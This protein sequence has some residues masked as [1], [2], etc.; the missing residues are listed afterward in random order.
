MTTTSKTCTHP[1]RR[2]SFMKSAGALGL[3]AVLPAQAQDQ[4]SRVQ[5]F[6]LSQVRLTA[7]PW[8]DAV[9]ANRRFLMSLEP[10]RLL[11]RFRENAGLP[12]KGQVY[13]G[14]E[15]D[16]IA[17]HTLG[18]YLSALSLMHAQ[19]GD[20]EARRRGDHI[21]AELALCQAQG[22]DGYVAALGRRV[23]TTVLND[24][25]SLFDDVMAGRIDP[26]FGNLNGG[27]APLYNIHKQLAGLLDAHLHLGNEQA[28]RVATG[29]AGYLDHVFSMLDEEKTQLVLDCEYGGLQESLAELYAR[30]GERRW[31]ALARRLRHEKTFRAVA[32]GRDQLDK[33]HSNTEMPKYVGSARLYEVG[34]GEDNAAATRFFWRTVTQHRSYVVGGNGDREWFYPKGQ[35]SRYITDQTCEHCSTYN[36]LKI[37]RHLFQWEPHAKWFDYYERAHLNHTLA[38]QDPATG[39]FAYMMPTMAGAKRT[40][41]QPTDQFWCCMGSG[42]E[43]HAKHGDSIWWHGGSA[44]APELFVNEY[45]PSM[46]DWP[47]VGTFELM[48][49]Y[50]HSERIDLLVTEAF[51]THAVAIRLRVPGWTRSPVLALN[52]KP[53]PVQV[54]DGYATLVRRLRQGDRIGLTLP[55]PLYREATPDNPSIHAYLH[56]PMALAADLGADGGPLLPDEQPAVFKGEEPRRLA[57]GAD[58]AGHSFTLATTTG[59]TLELRPF[60][61]QWNQRTALY[62]PSFDRQQWPA[63]AGRRARAKAQRQATIA[64]SVDIFEP[65]NPASEASHAYRDERTEL[66]PY[67]GLHGRLIKSGGGFIDVAMRCADRP[68]T[69]YVTFWG[70]AERGAIDI[71]VEGTIIATQTLN[72]DAPGEF[73]E[74]AYPIPPKLA[75]D[76]RKVRVRFAPQADTRGPSIY[77]VRMG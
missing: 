64:A 25:R 65:G 16:T 36:M 43:A 49:T 66:T 23:G 75:G 6:P 31:L 44:A 12:A 41:S 29:M 14:W 24:G 68:M 35:L 38:A 32:E 1:A 37:T 53:V 52:G 74:A 8:R 48:T 28:L 55:M 9:E 2:R 7:S 26:R 71:L 3:F 19:T 59:K 47:G 27:W 69:L 54:L 67:R 77:R 40:W 30:T 46:L 39:M 62:F 58:S 72:R 51:T 34:G 56:G 20:T 4:A 17:G 50:P 21:V 61:S 63:E 76:K 18:H 57:R 13:G 15:S 33:V 45:I 11:A 70:E 22:A 73:F 5:P 10:D 42:M 60:Y